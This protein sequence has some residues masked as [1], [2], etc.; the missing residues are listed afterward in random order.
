MKIY[1]GTKLEFLCSIKEVF[2]NISL[3]LWNYLFANIRLKLIIM[4][5][6]YRKSKN[7]ILTDT[8]KVPVNK[9]LFHEIFLILLFLSISPKFI[10]AFN[11]I[12]WLYIII[13]IFSRPS[14]DFQTFHHY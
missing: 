4:Q 10:F 2:S 11:I 1:F 3:E 7:N 5:K 6:F 14:I 8:I 13:T 12:P 9:I